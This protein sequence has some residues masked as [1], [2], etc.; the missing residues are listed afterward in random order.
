MLPATHVARK[1]QEVV[2]I[3]GWFVTNYLNGL[4]RA[5][6]SFSNIPVGMVALLLEAGHAGD[7]QSLPTLS[8]PIAPNCSVLLTSCLLSSEE[9]CNSYTASGLLDGCCLPNHFGFLAAWPIP[10]HVQ[11]CF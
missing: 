4:L 5:H 6:S 2:L 9:C 7:S 10:R 11:T 1:L 3:P 8:M